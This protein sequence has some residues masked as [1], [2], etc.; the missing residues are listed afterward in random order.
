MGFFSGLAEERHEINLSALSPPTS[1]TKTAAD[2][3][4]KAEPVDDG[5]NEQVEEANRKTHEAAEAKRKAEW[6]AKQEAKRAAE[7]EAIQRV[8]AMLDSQVVADAAKRVRT[9]TERLTRRNMKEMVTDH[10]AGLCAANPAFS[11][12]VMHPHKSMINCFKYINRKAR[13]YAEQEMKDLGIERTETY[14]CDVPD[15]LCYQWAEEYFRDTDVPEDKEGEE[16]FTPKP[17][18]PSRSPK[19]KTGSK[20]KAAAKT[21]QTKPTQKTE[22]SPQQCSLF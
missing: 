13:E 5:E 10:I 18:V 1:A 6:D 22:A 19:A 9:D 16:K 11:R 21:S 8:A 3:P 12:R 7:K 2:T 14:G 20:P 17:Y 4:P 15:G